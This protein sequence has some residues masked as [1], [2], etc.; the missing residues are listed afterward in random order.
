MQGGVELSMT[1]YSEIHEM[2]RQYSGSKSDSSSA[3]LGEI[4]D[5]P[6]GMPGKLEIL[7]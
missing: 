1:S 4:L 3:F 7:Q 2:V 5:S 6:I